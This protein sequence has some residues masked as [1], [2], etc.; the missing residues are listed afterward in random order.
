KPSPDGRSYRDRINA[1]KTESQMNT[2]YQDM[3]SEL[4]YGRTLLASHNPVHTGGPMQVSVAFAEAHARQRHYPYP[5]RDSI[6]SEVFSRRGGMYFGIAILLDYPAPYAEPI[7]RFADFNAGRY[8][9]RNAAFQHATARL[10]G[11]TLDLDGDL[12]RY[13]DGTPSGDPSDTQRALYALS[14]AL[15]MSQRE[16]DRD[17][18]SEK[19]TTFSQT[20]LYRKLFMLADQKSGAQVS[21][22]AIP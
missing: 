1:L 18:G 14:S 6:R 3:I 13:R 15:G 17:L 16:I 2:L 22:A 21:R 12:L 5:V 10:S 19:E 8:S 11:Q 4:P 20:R 7:Y 9:S